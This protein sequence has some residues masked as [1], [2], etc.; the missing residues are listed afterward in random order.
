MTPQVTHATKVKIETPGATV[1]IEAQAGLEE[2]AQTALRL[3]HQA[4]GWPRENT[5]A[6]G[7]AA[8]ERRDTPP[9]QPSGM[10]S[11]PGSYP[12]QLP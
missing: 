5:H 6:A 3:F 2:V 11:A 1:E 10:Y 8:A 7:F 12:V 4:G 9:V